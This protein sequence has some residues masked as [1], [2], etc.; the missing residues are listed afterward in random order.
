MSI[1]QIRQLSCSAVLSFDSRS[2]PLSLISNACVYLGQFTCRDVAPNGIATRDC[3]CTMLINNSATASLIMNSKY[4][5][6]KG[7]IHINRS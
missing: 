5:K 4:P 7:S 1:Y 2:D 6:G 3:I